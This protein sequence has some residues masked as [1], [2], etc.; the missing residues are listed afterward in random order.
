MKKTP[1]EKEKPEEAAQGSGGLRG[2]FSDGTPQEVDPAR[3]LFGDRD[4]LGELLARAQVKEDMIG[5][6]TRILVEGE[7]LQLPWRITLVSRLLEGTMGIE[8]LGSD[9]LFQ[10]LHGARPSADSLDT[11]KL[12]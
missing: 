5:L 7:Q 10:I 8:G 1:E 2:W 11:L 9:H 3:S 4:P 6:I 12:P